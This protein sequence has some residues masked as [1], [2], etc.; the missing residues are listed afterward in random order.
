MNV[1]ID[2]E[3]DSTPRI[4][5]E[6]WQ[7]IF[8]ETTA[9]QAYT[10]AYGL[11]KFAVTRSSWQD[12][13]GEIYTPGNKW[14]HLDH[15]I[16]ENT[17]TGG[18]S[19]NE[20]VVYSI[21]WIDLE[22]GGGNIQ[23]KVVCINQNPDEI[24]PQFDR[25][26][27]IQCADFNSDTFAYIG[28]AT[29]G[30]TAQSSGGWLNVIITSTSDEADYSDYI[31]NQ[32]IT[33]VIKCPTR[34]ALL[35][36]RTQALN[37]TIS[38]PNTEVNAITATFHNYLL[39]QWN[40]D[41][42]N[43]S[44]IPT[45]PVF[46]ADDI[47]NSQFKDWKII[48]RAWRENYYPILDPDIPPQS[49]GTLPDGSKRNPY[50]GR[51]GDLITQFREIAIG[52]EYWDDNNLNYLDDILDESNAANVLEVPKYQSLQQALLKV[53]DEGPGYI[54]NC[55]DKQAYRGE[56]EGEWRYYPFTAGN[57]GYVNRDFPVRAAIQAEGGLLFNT[58]NEAIY[59]EAHNSSSGSTLICDSTSGFFCKFQPSQDEPFIS[60]KYFWSLTLY[61]TTTRNFTQD[62]GSRGGVHHAIRKVDY[63]AAVDGSSDALYVEP[64]GSIIV[65]MQDEK[66]ANANLA[67]NWLPTPRDDDGNPTAFKLIWRFYGPDY[68][69]LIEHTFYPPPIQFTEPI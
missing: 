5:Y 34:W 65:H 32:N 21:C 53:Q 49:L 11:L 69:P 36:G 27:A 47:G 15:T 45:A 1:E 28:G 63:D 55:H 54:Q 20:D 66:P 29:D 26:I 33:K 52:P 7:S 59:I 67:K 39:S 50:P 56:L 62:V 18:L 19:P 38:D 57:A 9:W 10:Y 17:F 16:D 31:E 44:V 23:P 41:P 12:Q 13:N 24:N 25:Y 60:T 4:D 46:D 8:S 30:N 48:N 42:E 51:D 61:D 58:E 22:D 35:M 43:S 3:K 6:D 14:G 64:D 68:T 2:G 37:P 40:G